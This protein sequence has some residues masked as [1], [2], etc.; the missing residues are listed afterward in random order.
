LSEPLPNGALYE[1][2]PLRVERA[3]LFALSHNARRAQRVAD[4]TPERGRE[5]RPRLKSDG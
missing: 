1:Y 4:E 5:L 2:A 3:A